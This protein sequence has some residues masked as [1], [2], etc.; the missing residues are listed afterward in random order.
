MP[1]KGES[2]QS[3]QG[4]NT[5]TTTIDSQ[6]VIFQTKVAKL[7]FGLVLISSG[8]KWMWPIR[9]WNDCKHDLAKLDAPTCER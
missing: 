3:T 7:F 2:S 5:R 8:Q 6:Q 4:E 9:Y 1:A